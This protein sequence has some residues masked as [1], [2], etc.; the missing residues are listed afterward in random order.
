MTSAV[1]QAD[2]VRERQWFIVQRWTQF[3]AEARANLLRIL[4]VACFYTVELLAHYGILNGGATA[5]GPADKSFHLA[6]TALAAAWIATAMLVLLL[7]RERIFPKSLPFFSTAI[8]L[9]LLTALVMLADGPRSPLVVIYFLVVALTATRFDLRLL[10]FGSVGAVISYGFLLGYSR[11]VAARDVTVPRYAELIM[12]VA[13]VLM[14]VVLGQMIRRVRHMADDYAA[15]RTTA[16][17]TTWTSQR[18]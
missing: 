15:R 16:E 17:E 3:G 14:A 1:P 6:M 13:L 8:D 7:L 2:A 4:G 9:V 18:P 12:A 10:W 5:S 11:W